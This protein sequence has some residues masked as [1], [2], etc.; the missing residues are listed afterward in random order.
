M[1]ERRLGFANRDWI[2]LG[3][4]SGLWTSKTLGKLGALK[5]SLSFDAERGC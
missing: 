1:E 4:V 2:T 3:E 5:S